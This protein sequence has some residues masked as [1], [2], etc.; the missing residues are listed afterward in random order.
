MFSASAFAQSGHFLDRTVSCT[1]I[2][3]QASCSG[4]VAGLGGT[5]FQILVQAEG[6]ATVE[7]T[8]P[9]GNVA[10][11]QTKAVT[12]LGDSGPLPTPQNGNYTFSLA[13]ASPAAPAGSCPNDSWTGTVTDVSFTTATIQLFEDGTLSDTITV[14]VQ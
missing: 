4:K 7:C 14:A 2:G 6:Q 9:G 3:T 5:T 11:G 8:N 12:T 13:T 10:P 1:D